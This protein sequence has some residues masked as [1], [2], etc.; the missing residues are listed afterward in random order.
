MIVYE[1][2]DGVAYIR[3]NRPEVLNALNKQMFDELFKALESASKDQLVKVIVITGSGRAFTVGADLSELREFYERGE[4]INHG[5]ILRQRY[6]PLIMKL[7][8]I[9]KPVIA[10]ING[11]TAGAGIGIAL[12]AD[13]RLASSAAKF[14]LAFGRVALMPDSGLTFYLLRLMGHGRLFEWY[15]SNREMGAEE[16]LRLGLVDQI[17][18]QDVFDAKVHEFATSVASGPLKSYAL[19][20]RAINKQILPELTEALEYEAFLQEVAGYT[21]DHVEGVMAFIQKR[22]PKFK[23]N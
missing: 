10:A 2:K 19:L 5:D 12:S 20:K 11:V 8:T 23:G 13:I 17:Y 1:T 3:L 22:T 14:I 9:E 21:E 18:P 16:A 6:N 7:R 4:R 15:V